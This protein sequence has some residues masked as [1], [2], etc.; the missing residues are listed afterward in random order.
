MSTRELATS[1]IEV[2]TEIAEGSLSLDELGKAMDEA[3]DAYN[4]A[5]EAWL[6]L[7]DAVAES[8]KDDYARA[9]RKTDPAE[10]VIVT[11]TRRQHRAAFTTW[12][13]SK[14]QVDSIKEQIKAKSAAMNGRQSQLGALR[15]EMRA[16]YSR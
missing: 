11:E 6:E 15:D 3:V 1:P 9:G 8:M 5:D 7:Y 10:H 2:M 14:R 13:R 12:K 16:E 4:K